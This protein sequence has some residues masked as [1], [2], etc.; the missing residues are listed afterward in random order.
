[1]TDKLGL[2]LA[3]GGTVALVAYNS[4]L[5]CTIKRFSTIEGKPVAYLLK[6]PSHYT[7]DQLISLEPYKLLH[8][9]LFI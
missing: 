7:S 5:T 3:I 2:P 8:P 9:E 1:M 4:L 6:H